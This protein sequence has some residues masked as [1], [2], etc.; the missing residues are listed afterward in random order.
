MRKVEDSAYGGPRDVVRR[1]NGPG[2]WFGTGS[3]DPLA[4]PLGTCF[5]LALQ[6][7]AGVAWDQARIS[8]IE[9]SRRLPPPDRVLLPNVRNKWRINRLVYGKIDHNGLRKI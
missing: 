7:R 5:G 6:P 4:G 1:D 2:G 3:V 9:I 8:S